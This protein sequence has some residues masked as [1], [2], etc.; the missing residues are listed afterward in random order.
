MSWT[1]EQDDALCKQILVIEPFRYRPRTNQSGSAWSKVAGELNKM[2]SLQMKVV[3]Q[4]AVR[5]RFKTIKKKFQDKMKAE[6]TGFG[7]ASPELTP[8]EN[9]I[10]DI[11]ERELEM[12][13]LHGKEDDE[14][15]KKLEKDKKTA[16]E[17]RLQSLETFLETRKRK[18]ENSDEDDENPKP[19]KT[20]RSGS[21]T[22]LYLREKAQLDMEFKKEELQLKKEEQ[23][24]Q[25]EEQMA[26]RQQQSELLKSFTDVQQS[27][28]SQMQKQAELQQ[29]Q[30]QQ[31]NQ[32][33]MMMMQMMQSMKKN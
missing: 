5:D 29:Q 1:E 2:T 20:R 32:I 25:F 24:K 14:K 22:L 17:M 15:N 33:M 10:E 9:A 6:E 26:M 7:I 18:A 27:M 19:K 3:D 4:R 16:E 13:I 11:M 30:M 8:V 23:A 21:A 12:E 28:Q 31:N